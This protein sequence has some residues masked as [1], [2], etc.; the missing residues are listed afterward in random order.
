MF[1]MEKQSKYI[2]AAISGIL[3]LLAIATLDSKEIKRIRGVCKFE[4]LIY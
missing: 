4:R 3:V 2:V 1:K